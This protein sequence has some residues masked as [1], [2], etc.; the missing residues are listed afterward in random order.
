M[1]NTVCKGSVGSFKSVYVY[2]L[3]R[4]SDHMLSISYIGTRCMLIF[5]TRLCTLV[6]FLKIY[7]IYDLV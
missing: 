7:L 6:L 1:Y 4:L 3:K 2:L 5:S